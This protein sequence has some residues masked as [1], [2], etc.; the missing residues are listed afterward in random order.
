[1][2]TPNRSAAERARRLVALVPEIDEE[3]ARRLL[4]TLAAG[5]EVVTPP[6]AGLVMMTARDPFETA[7]CLGEVLVSE[8]AVRDGEVRGWGAVVGDAP[9]RA[10]L[11]ATVDLLGR[12][13]DGAALRRAAE[14]LAPAARRVQAARGLEAERVARTRVQFDLMPGK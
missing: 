14:A 11:A 2:D 9:Q 8:A 3:E 5:V 13:G 6:R 7:F 1:M 10:L 12:I 4:A